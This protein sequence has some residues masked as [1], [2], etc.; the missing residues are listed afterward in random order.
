M[1]TELFCLV[2]DFC[3]IF[4]PQ[5]NAKLIDS[6]Q[7]KRIKEGNMSISEIMTIIIYFHQSNYRT[8]KSYYLGLIKAH[9]GSYFSGLLSYPRFV[10]VMKR[11]LVPLC[12]FVHT[13]TGEKTGVYFTE[14]LTKC[15]NQ[16]MKF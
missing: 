5:W 13:L 11:V 6:K 1:L 14:V 10:A 2:D 7:K 12:A 16:I 4:L 15:Q 9:Y 8:F 3:K